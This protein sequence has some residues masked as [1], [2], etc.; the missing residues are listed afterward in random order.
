MAARGD[1]E[2]QDVEPILFEEWLKLD[3]NQCLDKAGAFSKMKSSNYFEEGEYPVIDQGEKYISGFVNDENLLYKGELPVIIF[4]DHTRIFKYVTKTFAVGADGTKILKP[5]EAFDAKFFFY[6]MKSLTVPSL[7]YSRHYKILNSIEVPLPPL[8]EQQRIVAKLDNLFGHLDALKTGLDRIPQ[9]LKDFRQKVLTQAVTGKLTE[10]WRERNDLEEIDNAFVCET[11]FDL[12]EIPES[13]IYSKV[14]LIGDVKGGKRLPLGDELIAEVTEHPYIRA[15]DLKQGTVLI[16]N[17]MYISEE[18]HK[19]IQ[20]YIVKEGDVY[21]TIVGAKIGDAGVIPLEMDGANLTENAAKITNYKNIEGDY[22]SIWLRSPIC[23][24]YILK[25]I[26]SAAQGKLAL[27]RINELPVYLTVIKEQ[28]EIVRRVESLFAKADQIEASYQKLKT[29]IEQLPQALL[30]KAFRGE[31]VEQ[32]P[33]DGD[34]R[35]LLEQI[36]QAKEGLEKGGKG[37][38]LKVEDEMRMVADRAAKYGKK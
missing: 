26:M 36:K 31:L 14:G 19:K 12:H 30:A 18:T 28:Q 29:K 20:R 4:G 6:Y 33:T 38:K 10:E 8:P 13:W 25:S 34:A 35:D 32:L 15:R 9:L 17:L 21:I 7:G 37:R 22:L 1:I 24:D 27:T 23:Q 5:I 2:N 3:F 11:Y 16:D